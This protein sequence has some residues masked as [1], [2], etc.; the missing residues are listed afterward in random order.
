MENVP[1][2]SL[3]DHIKTAIDV[4]PWAKEMAEELL[5]RQ[6]SRVVNDWISVKDKKRPLLGTLVIVCLQDEKTRRV[7]TSYYDKYK[8]VEI[9]SDIPVGFEVTHW[10]PL[11]EP[12]KES[13]VE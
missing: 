10:I 4:D 7:R 11:P 9:W 5:K 13:D 6:E 1:I 2:Q 12:P 3:I 8:G